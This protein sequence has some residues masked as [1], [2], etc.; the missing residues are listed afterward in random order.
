MKRII[1]ITFLLAGVFLIEGCGSGITITQEQA[2]KLCE[3]SIAATR[4]GNFEY[5]DIEIRNILGK[6][7]KGVRI[8]NEGV[9]V[10]LKR[11]LA[12]EDGIF[13]ATKDGSYGNGTDPSYERIA[14][15][16]YYY[17]ISG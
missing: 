11:F 15:C 9:Y 1:I 13:I 10:E 14:E 16:V 12:D 8:N 5:L 7:I 17:H 6:R 4:S 3:L 2:K